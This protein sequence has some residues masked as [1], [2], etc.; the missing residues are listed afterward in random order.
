MLPLHQRKGIGQAIMDWGL[1][2]ADELGLE[3][4]IE[5][6][7][8]GRKLYERCGCR[9]VARVDVDM[10][11]KGDAR[12]KE[13]KALQGEMLPCGYDSMWRPVR[14]VWMEDEP[15]KSWGEQSGRIVNS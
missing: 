12:G 10:E 6:T 2:R 8:A 9:V 3:T 15:Q 1:R 4:Y 7:A 5:A 14:G 13:W 11:S